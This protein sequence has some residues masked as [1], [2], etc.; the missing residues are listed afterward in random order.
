MGCHFLL[1]GIFPTQ[2]S[3]WHLLRLL[4]CRRILYPLS[5]QEAV[6]SP[7]FNC[8]H[9]KYCLVLAMQITQR[10]FCDA[11]HLTRNYASLTLGEWFLFASFSV[12]RKKWPLRSL[13]K[14]KFLCRDV[15]K[16][17]WTSDTVQPMCFSKKSKPWG[18]VVD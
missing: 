10:E 9:Q 1:Q 16:Q 6:S 5:H 12:S 3:N 13:T 17:E 15:K 2:E 14:S 18:P 11:G 4:H 7:P 8:P